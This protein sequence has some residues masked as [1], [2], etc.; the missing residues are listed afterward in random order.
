MLQGGGAA[1][2][3]ASLL[4]FVFAGLLLERLAASLTTALNKSV[5][6]TVLRSVCYSYLNCYAIFCNSKSVVIQSFYILL[7]N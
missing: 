1:T 3:P 2:A 7:I 4:R 5:S 6:V